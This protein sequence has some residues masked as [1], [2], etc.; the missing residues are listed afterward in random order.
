MQK[1][2]K[3]KGGPKPR[4]SP[5]FMRTVVRVMLEENLSYREVAKRYG[6]TTG[7][8]VYNWHKKYS[9]E[10]EEIKNDIPMADTSDQNST[11]ERIKQLEKALEKAK[12]KILGLET[13]IDVAESE[14]KIE[15]RKKSGTKPSNS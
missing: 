5:I 2:T 4:Y 14:L 3:S 9:S 13:M 1:K 11:D 10:I 8:M 12:L 15:I 7:S 6:L